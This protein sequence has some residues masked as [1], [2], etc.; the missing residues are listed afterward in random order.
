MNDSTEARKARHL[1]ICLED[2]VTSRLDAG[3]EAVR[4]HHEALPEFALADVDITT[5]F[6]GLALRAPLIIS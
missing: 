1:D 2:D 6:L 5:S 3:W 4:L